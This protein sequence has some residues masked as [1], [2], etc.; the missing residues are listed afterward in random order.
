MAANKTK[1]SRGHIVMASAVL[2]MLIGVLAM[3]MDNFSNLVA[4]WGA[5]YAM[6]VDIKAKNEEHGD[7]IPDHK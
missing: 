2:V 1:Q 3:G 6:Y 4:F 7:D 5:L